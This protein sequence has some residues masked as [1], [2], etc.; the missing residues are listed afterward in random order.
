MPA[1]ATTEANL[2]ANLKDDVPLLTKADATTQTNI[3]AAYTN[4]GNP[5]NLQDGES[6]VYEVGEPTEYADN[7]FSREI[8]FD[9]DLIDKEDY[10]LDFS[11]NGVEIN[12]T[13]PDGATKE[14]ILNALNKYLN[15]DNIKQQLEKKHI[16]FSISSEGVTFNAPNSLII[17]SNN[18]NVKSSAAALLKYSHNPQENEF[19]TF[20][21][22]INDMQS[23]IDNVYQDVEVSFNEGK[24]IITNNSTQNVNSTLLKTNNT[25]DLLFENFG[26]LSSTIAPG[27]ITQS[28]NFYIN[29]QTLGG[30]IY[31]ADGEKKDMTFEFTKVDVNSTGTTWHGVITIDGFEPVEADFTFDTEGKL[32][33]PKTLNLQD[34]PIT[35]NFDLTNYSK[36]NEGDTFTQNGAGKGE[37]IDYQIDSYGQIIATFD[38]AT[39]AVV[40]QIPIFHFVND[41]GLDNIGANLF[42]PTSNSGDPM[43]FKDANS[44]P[45]NNS[46]ILSNSL[47]N[48]NVNFTSAMTELIVTQRAFQAAAKTVT[49]SDQMIQKAID[50]KR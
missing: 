24:I 11:V 22:L 28:A 35:L 43:L 32:L 29:N 16:T 2:Q 4:A 50:M 25:N 39:S 26:N 12:L 47:E 18:N 33:E 49:T 14:D 10:V 21:D 42:T 8:C 15:Q 48:S 20:N 17:K 38:N 31:T 3:S 9:N 6:F 34:P 1:K 30:Y 41:E 46:Q 27:S 19:T 23:L 45:F 40:G 5:I 44:N 13:L 7:A 36:V 37:L